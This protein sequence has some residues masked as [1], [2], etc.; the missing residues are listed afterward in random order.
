MELMNHELTRADISA[1]INLIAQEMD[2]LNKMVEEPED[3]AEEAWWYWS[4]IRNK[5]HTLASTIR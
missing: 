3:S 2:A 5:L 1:I 4:G